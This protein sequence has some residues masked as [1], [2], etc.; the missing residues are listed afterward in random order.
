MEGIKVTYKGQTTFAAIDGAGVS[1]IIDVLPEYNY[2]TLGGYDPKTDLHIGWFA[3]EMG[4]ED[5][6]EIELV[7]ISEVSNHNDMPH[8]EVL[9][10]AQAIVSDKEKM[11][12]ANEL[13]L[14][15]YVSLRKYLLE[16]N[17]ISQ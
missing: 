6:I 5:D 7:E 15:K 4:A 10:R 1:F 9:D 3:K 11:E 2:I 13:L 8:Q 16:N 14:S 17:V 12:K